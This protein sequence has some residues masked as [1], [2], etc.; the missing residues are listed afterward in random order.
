MLMYG[1]HLK[2][3]KTNGDS[4]LYINMKEYYSIHVSSQFMKGNFK[5]FS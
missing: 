4:D 3:D 5:F 2:I 1:S